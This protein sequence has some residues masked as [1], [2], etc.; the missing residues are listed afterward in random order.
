[1]S[2]TSPPTGVPSSSRLGMQQPGLAP[3]HQHCV[4]AVKGSRGGMVVQVLATLTPSPH[5]QFS[6]LVVLQGL[7][8][9][10]LVLIQSTS[11]LRVGGLG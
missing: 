3:R 7:G 2:Y 10:L 6:V 11:P 5:H 9:C 4:T 8:M 1:M